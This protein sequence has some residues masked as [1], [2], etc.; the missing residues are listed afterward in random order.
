MTCKGPKCVRTD[1]H[2]KGL[3]SAHDMQM[4]RWGEMTPLGTR[5]KHT[6]E[7]KIE[8]RA[9]DNPAWR[10]CA[11]CSWCLAGRNKRKKAA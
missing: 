2:A 3:C 4:H 11:G 10:P 1:I 6:Q 5:R 8:R 7:E 9:R